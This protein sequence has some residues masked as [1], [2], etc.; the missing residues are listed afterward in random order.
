MKKLLSSFLSCWTNSKRKQDKAIRGSQLAAADYVFNLCSSVARITTLN[1][2]P[3]TMPVQP[4]RRDRS[5]HQSS[6]DNSPSPGG[7]GDLFLTEARGSNQFMVSLN[8]RRIAHHGHEPAM[9]GTARCA[10]TARKAGGTIRMRS[11]A[12]RF[13]EREIRAAWEVA[14]RI[15]RSRRLPSNRASGCERVNRSNENVIRFKSSLT[16]CPIWAAFC[17]TVPLPA[18]QPT[19]CDPGV[20]RADVAAYH[21]VKTQS[22]TFPVLR[23]SVYVKHDQVLASKL[24]SRGHTSMMKSFSTPSLGVSFQSS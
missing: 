18:A 4:N 3:T 7:E 24:P 15:W 23:S 5:P 8:D 1:V 12:R 6:A 19:F 10:V 13:M 22:R 17:S 16:C 14:R 11:F 9:V 21:F 2:T 20:S